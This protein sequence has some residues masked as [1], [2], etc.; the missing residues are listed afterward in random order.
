M[1]ILL[2]HLLGIV[3][4]VQLQLC[5]SAFSLVLLPLSL[6]RPIFVS[7][8]ELNQAE[9]GSCHP[10]CLSSLGF[11]PCWPG[12]PVGCPWLLHPSSR[13]PES[14]TDHSGTAIPPAHFF[15]FSKY[16]FRGN[17][18]FWAFTKKKKNPKPNKTGRMSFLAV[19]K[20]QSNGFFAFLCYRRW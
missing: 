11:S 20:K 16:M 5:P 14:V 12:Q 10:P 13:M 1:A 6:P 8:P 9:A 7:L 17:K 4:T 3:S 18:Y 15:P 19:C 2:V